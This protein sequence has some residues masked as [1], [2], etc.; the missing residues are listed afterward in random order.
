MLRKAVKQFQLGV[1][2]P[3]Q[4][5]RVVASEAKMRAGI[6]TLRSLELAVTWICNLDCKFCYAEDLMKAQRRPPD[7]PVDEV[8]RITREA[9]DLGLIPILELPEDS[10]SPTERPRGRHPRLDPAGSVRLWF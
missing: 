5:A 7:M 3:R 2:S 9:H 1:K 8:A 6:R 4:A 10:S